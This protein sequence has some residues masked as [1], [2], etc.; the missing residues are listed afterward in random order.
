[1]FC[2]IVDDK[3]LF[4]TTDLDQIQNYLHIL[5]DSKMKEKRGCERNYIV[6]RG[7]NEKDST[8]K[9]KWKT[10]FE[11]RTSKMAHPDIA[12]LMKQVQAAIIK[13]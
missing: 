6:V 3:P 12:Y 8:D 5:Y 2:L 11:R 13:E 9:S 7:F 4:Y 10:I 1:M